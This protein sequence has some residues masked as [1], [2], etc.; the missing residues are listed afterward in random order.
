MTTLAPLRTN[1]ARLHRSASRGSLESDHALTPLVASRTPPSSYFTQLHAVPPPSYSSAASSLTSTYTAPLSPPRSRSVPHL[2]N[3]SFTSFNRPSEWP[4]SSSTS[5]DTSRPNLITRHS[6]SSLPLP[7]NEPLPPPVL[8][9]QSDV[10]DHHDA[11]QGSEDEAL[12]F[13]RR[14]NSVAPI[15]TATGLTSSA[16]NGANGLQRRPEGKVSRSRTS[17]GSMEFAVPPSAQVSSQLAGIGHSGSSLQ[18]AFQQPILPSSRPAGQAIP[19]SRR[20]SLFFLFLQSLSVLPA[21]LGFFYSVHRFYRHEPPLLNSATTWADNGHSVGV[22]TSRSTR[23]DWFLSGGWALACAYFS[24]SLARGLLRRWL[25]YYSLLPTIIR[26]LSLQAICWPLTLTTHRFLSF[27]QP[28]A[29][30]LVCATTAAFSVSDTL[31]TPGL[32]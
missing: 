6:S 26:V 23:L 28:I 2:P 9:P 7:L 32:A 10:Y 30:W 12:E 11:D 24:H 8:P 1:D 31:T 5:P 29:A 18:A 17:S 4:A 19:A 13:G 27:D 16:S 14:R 25:V 20:W 22:V 15:A 3:L 21:L